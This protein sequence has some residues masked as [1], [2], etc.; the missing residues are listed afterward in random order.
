M[1]RVSEGLDALQLHFGFDDAGKD[2]A[3]ERSRTSNW[4][5]EGDPW[6]ARTNPVPASVVQ[7]FGLEL[8]DLSFG[9][10]LSGLLESFRLWT[11][12]NFI[13]NTK[14]KLYYIESHE[15]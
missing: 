12:L 8:V 4:S 3:S 6:K 14:L 13:S 7:R 9:S 10:H 1:A 2:S 15:N 5:V 11:S